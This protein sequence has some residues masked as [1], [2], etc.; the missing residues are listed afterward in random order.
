MS[1][2]KVTYS[3]ISG[4]VFN[5]LDY[6]A[7][8]SATAAVNTAAINN[9]ITDAVA[10]DRATVYIPAGIYLTNGPI[11][12]KSSV[13]LVGDGAFVSVL[14]KTG[15]YVGVSAGTISPSVP[16]RTFSVVGIGIESEDFGG[17]GFDFQ[18]CA[19]FNIADISVNRDA[20][21]GVSIRSS[22]IGTVGSMYSTR[23][24]WNLYFFGVQSV[25][26]NYLY[27]S[28]PVTG[29]NNIGCEITACKS[30]VFNN[31][32]TEG[33]GKYGLLVGPVTTN[34]AIQQWYF[35]T[36]TYTS[37][38]TINALNMNGGAIGDSIQNF[39]IKSATVNCDGITTA[40][41]LIVVTN[42]VLN[43][44]LENFRF[45]LA[46]AANYSTTPVA[47]FNVNNTNADISG[48]RITNWTTSDATTGSASTTWFVHFVANTPDARIFNTIT[49]KPSQYSQ[50]GTTRILP[51]TNSYQL[52][53][54]PIV[55]GLVPKWI[56]DFCQ[57][58]VASR[59]YIANTTAA[60]DWT[61]I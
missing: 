46:G 30:L 37:G 40:S 29:S 25:Q 42:S 27:S 9:A 5:V 38:G 34:I 7:S 4:A 49:T 11:V 13:N 54:S 35:E 3:M 26:F 16:C 2:T 53:G 33:D 52:A 60:G 43:L 50:Y 57:D 17:N 44:V 36:P 23:C 61:L 32:V 48:P 1:L 41:P 8:P 14:K 51:D 18:D 59:M 45:S 10:A 19:Y 58:S 55:A 31:L 12:V 39:Q 47:R 28:T 24:D 6:G 22:F 15:A 21:K 20:G 56:G